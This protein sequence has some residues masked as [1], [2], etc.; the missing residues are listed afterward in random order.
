ML[1]Q[2]QKFLLKICISVFLLV[3]V[4]TKI[5]WELLLSSL[6][7]IDVLFYIISTLF[8]FFSIIIVACKYYLLIN[9]TQ[10]RRSIPFLIKINIIGRYYALFLPS[11]VG[12][13]V[14]RWFKVTRNQK[15]RVFF[16]AATL[17]ERLTF[18]F[19][20]LLFCILPLIYYPEEPDILSFR[21]KILPLMILIF[22]VSILFLLYFIFPAIQVWFGQL[23]SR[24]PVLKNK[25]N[26]IHFFLT[27]FSLS[28]VRPG[29]LL[30][31]FILSLIFQTCFLGRLFFLIKGS[32]IPLAFWDIA[33][34][35]SLVL[36][37]QILPVSLAGIGVREGAYA[38]LFSLF[39]LPPE[40]GVL[41]G[42]LLFSQ[43]LIF[44]GI[45]GV[46][47]YFEK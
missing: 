11:A 9:N 8:T 44:A 37:L 4:F 47:E 27:K 39:G 20:L 43:M 46:L 45:G 14:V 2:G 21:S 41:I 40:K 31:I 25:S 5:K 24:I 34:I 12:Q 35:G 32:Y 17:F 7:E 16:A 33:W 6:G 29:F 3:W 15:G 18:I 22:I 36:F 42:I 28:Q 26:D 30:N 19:T 38:F 23:L 1:T 13:A 10:I